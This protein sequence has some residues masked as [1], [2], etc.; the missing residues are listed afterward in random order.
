MALWGILFH[1]WI[2][3][4]WSCATL[5]GTLTR[6]LTLLSN[7]SQRCSIG[8]KS[9]L[10]GGQSSI[11]TLF[12]LRKSRQTLA[13]CGLALSCW[14]VRLWALSSGR[15][16]GISTW[17]RQCTAVRLP[18]ITTR[19]VFTPWEIPPQTIT[20]RAPPNLSTS[21]T[22]ASEYCSPKRRYT[23]YRLSDRWSENRDS[24]LNI[25]RRVPASRNRFGAWARSHC[26]RRWRRLGVRFG[27]T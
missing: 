20:D 17:S 8:F 26:M 22:Q 5:F 15:T 7:A 27:P 2:R 9:G 13:T 19:G 16:W 1:S 18:W 6:F 12:W 21:R 23:R 14:N 10:Y 25:T 4:S 3:A 11:W 24:S